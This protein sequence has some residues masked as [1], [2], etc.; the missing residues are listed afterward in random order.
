MS[1]NVKLKTDD[2]DYELPESLIAKY[3][4]QVRDQSRLL[5]V[6]RVGEGGFRDLIFKDIVQYFE[7]GDVLVLNDTKV[8]PARLYGHKLSGAKIELLIE[9]IEDRQVYAHIRANKALKPNQCIQVS[10]V[11]L[12]VL[13]K[14]DSLY[15]LECV[16]G[17]IEAVMNEEGEIPL[18]PY[19]DRKA[20]EEDKKRYQTVYA[21]PQGS[22]A[23]P[24]AGLHFTNDLLE[25]LTKK[26]VILE[27][28]TLHVGAGTFKPVQSEEILDHKMHA[29]RIEVSQK[30]VNA[31]HLAKSTGKKV[32]AVGTTSVRV[33]ESA[34][35]GEGKLKTLYGETD[36]FLYPGKVFQIIDGMVTNFHLPKSSLLM[37]VS[38]FASHK[39]IMQA[40]RHAV[41]EGYRFYSYGDA[42]L[43]C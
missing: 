40:Y 18:P 13:S 22:V 4:T 2:F 17:N 23:A 6:P 37:L 9:R 31:V 8:M 38:A 26:G 33:L 25:K 28:V 10:D 3:P 41:C 1:L 5:Q 29:E 35:C 14:L 11:K 7:A 19:M 21:N 36:L 15:L 43:I 39:Q 42:M 12:R 27:Y 34:A 24:T 32:F 16:K 30:V 20:D